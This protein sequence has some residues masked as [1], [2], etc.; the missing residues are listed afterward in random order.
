MI[1]DLFPEWHAGS[2]SPPTPGP[3]AAAAVGIA[4][5]GP[6]N[7]ELLEATGGA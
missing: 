3:Q 7:R 2:G 6:R 1:F 4:V 5:A